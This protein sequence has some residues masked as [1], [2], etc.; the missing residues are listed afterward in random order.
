MTLLCFAE[1]RSQME[2]KS[3]GKGICETVSSV[4]P[5]P[6]LTELS[7]TRGFLSVYLLTICHVSKVEA[8]L[9]YNQLS[10]LITISCGFDNHLRNS[11]NKLEFSNDFPQQR[12]WSKLMLIDQRQLL[13]HSVNFQCL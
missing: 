13:G 6:N 10:L 9:V 3:K 7:W 12:E 11:E 8:C 1:N 4:Q 5:M 2:N